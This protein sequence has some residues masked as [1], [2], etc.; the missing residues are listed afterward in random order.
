MKNFAGLLLVLFSLPSHAQ[1]IKGKVCYEK[2]KTAVQFASIALVQLPD[3]SIVTG[4]I[5]L[6]D[7]GY[8]LEKVKPGNYFVRAGYLGY[9]PSGKAVIVNE[10]KAEISIDTIFLSESIA[11]LN[12]V[13]VTGERLKGQEM[14]DR[15][16]YKIPEVVSKSSVN[17]YDLLKKVPQVNVDFQNNVTLNGSSNF[18]IE[19]DGRRRDKEFL[20]RLMPSDIQSIEIISNPSGKYEGNIDGVLS[21]ILKKEARFGMNGNVALA[22]KPL[23]ETT[24]VGSGS[25][26][27][28]T[29]KMRYYVTCVYI[30]Q[31][32]DMRMNT[33]SRFLSIDSLTE[34]NA[35][36]KISVQMPTLNSGFD[37]FINERNNISFNVS[38]KPVLQTMELPGTTTLFKSG[39]PLN[40]VTSLTSQ[41]MKSDEAS[42]S[43][44]FK[45]TFSKPVEEFTAEASL[46]KFH[47]TQQND[48]TNETHPYNDE[49]I[50]STYSRLEDD[51]NTRQ[52]FSTKLDFVYPLGMYAKFES[53]YQMYYQQMGYDF[54]INDKEVTNL[55]EYSELRYSGYAGLTFNIKKLGAQAMLRVENTHINA[56]S[57]SKPDYSCFLPTVNLQYKFSSAHNLKLTYNR[58]INRPG[59]YDMNPN[60]KF[61]QDYAISVGNPDLRPDYRD[62]LQLTH[63]WNFGSNYLAPYI[64][65]EFFSDRI[66]NRYS[67]VRS[68]VDGTF[69]AISR[70]YNLING[71]ELGGGLNAMLWYININA[72]V[73]KGHYEGY[74]ESAF[75]IPA[76]DYSSFSITGNAFKN[77]DKKK[78]TTVFLFTQYNGVNVNAQSKT[79]TKLLYGTGFQYQLKSHNLGLFWMVPFVKRDMVYQRIETET[80]MYSSRKNVIINFTG[81]VQ[82]QYR[83][84]FNIGRNVKKI[85]RK[86]EVES[87]SKGQAIGR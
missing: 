10:G 61:G 16:V 47:S 9:H 68:P 26:D 83:Y 55:W 76:R 19:V 36:G 85:D 18:I 80:G 86:I 74:S 46:Y 21:I 6:I 49:Q 62:R 22:L 60:E 48:F 5:T 58:R 3:S 1:I 14:V 40:Y 73:Y 79:Y 8:S 13:T 82:F 15:T 39:N 38:Y 78:K 59:I 64:Y 43:V 34:M 28:S 2:D 27:Y 69:T 24:A 42:A 7:G 70:P 50:L 67:I 56:D 51:I 66:G 31:K 44:Y 11:S 87:D 81:W 54:N 25:I 41:V 4:A 71:Y 52:Y 57:V 23:N 33:L 77:L 45:R 75:P 35:E 29:G 72:R 30:G 63:T 12:E 17:G 53:G 32:L 65:D 20:A 84:K 37:Y